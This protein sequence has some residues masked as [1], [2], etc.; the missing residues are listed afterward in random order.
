MIS[1]LSKTKRSHS[2]IPGSL[3]PCTFP[4]HIAAWHVLPQHLS[5]AIHLMA[6]SPDSASYLHIPVSV[7]SYYISLNYFQFQICVYDPLL[8]DF[9]APC[10]IISSLISRRFHPSHPTLL[11]WC[12]ICYVMLCICYF[13]YCTQKWTCWDS[14]PGPLP[15][16]G[17]DLPTDLQAL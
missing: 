15:C 17:S 11:G 2:E 4:G 6:Y 10:G 12:I 16:K 3:V 14:N 9:I 5:R 8:H 13:M 1:L 7:W